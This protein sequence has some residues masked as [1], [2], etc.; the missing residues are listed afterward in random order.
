M[1]KCEDYRAAIAAEPS[2][3]FDGGAGHA[4]ACT[5]CA[6]FKAEMQSLDQRIARALTINVPK[7]ELPDLRPI[8]VDGDTRVVNLPFRRRATM[9]VPAWLG[10]AA[11]FALVAV[12]A[13]QYFSAGT[14]YPSLADEIVAHLD[15]EPMALKVTTEGVSESTLLDVVRA[16][17]VELSADLGLVTYARTCVINGN[18]IPHLVI[19]GEKGPVTL[20]L[21]PDEEIDMAVPLDGK[22]VHGVLLPVGKGSVAIIGERDERIGEIEQRV[23]DSVTWSI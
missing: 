23:I 1:M 6:E 5:S 13:T 18:T 11:A 14:G 19:Q 7:L 12:V 17:V 10:V 2:E 15:H 9:S 8:K 16:D 3:A 21:L 20:L 4:A 22:A